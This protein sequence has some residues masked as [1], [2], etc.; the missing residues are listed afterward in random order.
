MV[1]TDQ[2]GD[3]FDLPRVCTTVP[4]WWPVQPGPGTEPHHRLSVATRR[5]LAEHAK[6]FG[7]CEPPPPPGPLPVGDLATAVR[8]GLNPERTVTTRIRSRL[9]LPAGWSPPDPLEPVLAAPEFP[10]PMYRAVAELA[11]DLLLPDA[12]AVPGNSVCLV[13]TNP[14]FVQALMAGL[15]HEMGRELL[16][17]GYPTDQ[18]GTCF[19]RFWDRAGAVPRLTGT[20]LDDIRPIPD[21]PLAQPLGTAGLPQPPED[22]D[23]DEDTASAL[24]LLIRGELLHR[25]PRT[26]IY[27]AKAAW[28]SGPGSALTLPDDAA[29]EH[30]RFG[31]TLPTDVTFFGF[32]ISPDDARG[33]TTDPGWYIVFQQQPTEARFGLDVATPSA[34][35]GTWGDLSWETVTVSGSG[36]VVLG[37]TDPITVDPAADPRRL[38]F[39]TAATSA[40][41]A[42]IVEQ[43]PY[44]VAVHARALLPEPPP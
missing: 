29:E 34:P 10:T 20:Q 33:T 28:R 1:T 27:A 12:N 23:G 39:T 41:I 13:G 21:W 3:R 40:Q 42:A 36:H 37:A 8:T 25:Y 26:T 4:A 2:I 30:P 44:R 24:V 7:P 32:G 22:G 6:G 35:T 19:R 5:V 18:R 17:R 14:W 16:W 15:N 38:H 11:P 43:R 31:G 9:K